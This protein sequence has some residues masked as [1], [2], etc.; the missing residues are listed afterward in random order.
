MGR[1]QTGQFDNLIR[2]L[3][4]IKGG[5][6]ELSET[7]GDLFPTLDLEN[8]PIELLLLRGW[9]TFAR[10]ATQIAVAAQATALQLLQPDGRTSIV[11]VDKIVINSELGGDI[12]IGTNLG[13][14]PVTISTRRTDTRNPVLD[15]S[16]A[17]IGGT[18]NAGFGA[19]GGLLNL[20][21]GV[22]R[23]FEVPHGLA[24]LGPGGAFSVVSSTVD[25]DLSVSFFGRE[26]DAEPS[27][28]NF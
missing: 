20:A 18:N 28:L 19:T 12:S 17:Q 13:L 11:V 3:Y 16:N 7:L 15:M 10:H 5:G 8:L 6:S 9:H 23:E 4:S 14:F 21:A 2:R 24:V 27:E 26:R 25:S 22:D 1:V